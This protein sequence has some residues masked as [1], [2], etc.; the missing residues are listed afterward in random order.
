MALAGL[1][2]GDPMKAK[3]TT[4]GRSPASGC[5]VNAVSRSLSGTVNVTTSQNLAALIDNAY[6]MLNSREARGLLQAIDA[7]DLAGEDTRNAAFEY[8]E[9]IG[10]RVIETK[11]E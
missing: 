10:I 5:E 2:G 8:L 9:S 4:Y 3:N 11:G 6:G 1:S 7:S